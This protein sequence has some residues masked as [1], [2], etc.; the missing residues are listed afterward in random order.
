MF[1]ILVTVSFGFY[2]CF[3]GSPYSAVCYGNS[4][5]RVKQAFSGTQT[6]LV[7]TAKY[8]KVIM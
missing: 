8:T 4:Q 2:P 1:F 7:M 3:K 5:T 6:G